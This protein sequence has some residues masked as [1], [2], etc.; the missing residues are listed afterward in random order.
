M[1]R[2]GAVFIAALFLCAAALTAGAGEPGPAVRRVIVVSVDGL[3]PASYTAPDAHGLAV[4]TLREMVQNGAWSA[5]AL[6]V[7]PSITYPAH[8]SIATGLNPGAHG[9]VTNLVFDPL[10]KNQQG[11]R[12]YAEDIRAPAL[13]DAA[14]ARALKIGRAHV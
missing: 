9:I 11:W 13:W 10:G 8:T 12:W 5:G 14:R 6:S 2:L 3:V 7:F 4:P 1:R